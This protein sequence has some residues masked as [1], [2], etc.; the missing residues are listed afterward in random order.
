MR[1]S[2]VHFPPF[3]LDPS[4]ERLWRE[5]VEIPLRPKTFAV[6]RY[7]VGHPEQLVTKEELLNA[8]WAETVVGE[9]AL[10]GCIRDLRKVLGDEAKRPQYIET[11]H[12]RGFRFIGKVASDQLPVVR[13]A[14]E[15][16]SQREEGQKPVL[17]PSAEPVVSEVELL[18]INSVEGTK[19]EEN[20][21][22]TE[23]TPPFDLGLRTSNF[24]LLT[25]GSALRTFLPWTETPDARRFCV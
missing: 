17:S 18:R 12:R 21:I 4:N 16:S 23:R 8:V 2:L 6:L 25:Q 15:A 5:R 19:V 3:R 20:G 1:S 24:E 22:G 7:L 9:D 10:T 14:E 11:V 13:Q